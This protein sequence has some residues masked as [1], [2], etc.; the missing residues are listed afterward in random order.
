MQHQAPHRTTVV[1]CIALLCLV[2]SN[3]WWA[4]R[5]SLEDL[6]PLTAAAAR[7]WLAGLVMIPVCKALRAR[8]RGT[9]PPTWLWL[10]HGL[11]AFALSFGV[12]YTC[13]QTVPSGIAAVVWA[14]FPGLMAVSGHFV[15]GERLVARKVLGFA[16]AFAGIPVLF[17]EDFGTGATTS[18]ILLLLASPVVSAISTTLVKKFGPHHSSLVLNRN[19]MLT[20]ALGLGLA[21]ALGERDR[22]AHW[23]SAAIASVVFLAIIGSCLTFGIYYWLLR[24]AQATK[25]SL[26]S[27]VTPCLALLIGWALDDGTLGAASLAGTA[28]ITLGVVL[29]VRSPAAVRAG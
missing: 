17:A 22:A 14:V 12:L 16:L 19:G 8:E 27:Y 2:W 18:D 29:V 1:A 9:D 7:F 21:A 26:I 24:S 25:L 3:T 23:T 4:I 28:L 11:C 5:R 13:E 15:L 20:G 6:P 10:T